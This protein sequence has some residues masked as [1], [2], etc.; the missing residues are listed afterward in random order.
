MKVRFY[1]DLPS[2]GIRLS[3][4]YPWVLY[5]TTSPASGFATDQTRVAFDVDMPPNL[6]LPPQDVVAPAEPAKVVVVGDGTALRGKH[7]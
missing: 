7:D 2:S 1:C 4:A 5:A 3:G 6:V